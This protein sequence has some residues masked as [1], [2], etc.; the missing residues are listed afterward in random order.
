MS[1]PSDPYRESIDPDV[2]CD[3]CEAVCCR[4]TVVLMP[5]DQVPDWLVT[6]DANGLEVLAKGE[7]GWCAAIDANRMCCSIYEDR[8]AICRKYAMG[9]PS[10]RDER[11]KWYRQPLPTPV[12]V[13]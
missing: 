7:D 1:E 12:M 6:H 10:C 5:E 8:P 13:V 11:A 2:H 4:L 9:S 3:A